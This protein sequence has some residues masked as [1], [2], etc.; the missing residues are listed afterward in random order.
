MKKFMLVFMLLFAPFVMGQTTHK[1][2]LSWTPSTSACVMSQNVHRVQTQGSEVI[3]N[4]FAVVP[5]G[6]STFTDTTVVAGATYWWTVSVYGS[7]C[8]PNGTAADES[9][10]SN[11]VKTIIPA[12]KPLPA[13][14][15]T[16]TVQ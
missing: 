12:D 16:A 15:L 11:E 9:V 14:G 1:V 13:T 6:S 7:S 3:G 5:V 10:M 8:D 2:T 4:N